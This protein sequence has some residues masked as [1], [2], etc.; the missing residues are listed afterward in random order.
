M[1]M[2]Y[3]VLTALKKNTTTQKSAV[4]TSSLSLTH[5]HTEIIKASSEQGLQNKTGARL[6]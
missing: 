2:M 1:E 3:L 6:E 5:H 4:L